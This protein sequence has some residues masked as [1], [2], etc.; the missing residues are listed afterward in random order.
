MQTKTPPNIDDYRVED[1]Y[2]L[3]PATNENVIPVRNRIKIYQ[4]L[5]DILGLEISNDTMLM[6]ATE[7]QYELCVAT[8]GAG[9]T[10]TANVKLVAEKIFRQSKLTPGSKLKG[11]QCLVLL[12]NN[13]NHLLIQLLILPLQFLLLYSNL[14]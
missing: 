13:H 8:A 10:T 7:T 9:K 2:K 1:L 12:Y 6:L 5:F 11:E 3:L 4:M 14:L